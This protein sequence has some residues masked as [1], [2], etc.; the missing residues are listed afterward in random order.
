[1]GLTR[2]TIVVE[3]GLSIL[4]TS[5][6]LHYQILGAHSRRNK[7]PNQFMNIVG[8]CSSPPDLFRIKMICVPRVGEI[9]DI[10]GG[11]TYEVI[12]VTYD[13]ISIAEKLVERVS[14]PDPTTMV[15]LEVRRL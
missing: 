6:P 7:L 8:H 4:E 9:L 13:A 12:K 10:Q 14:D 1:M 5:G 11:R 3:S 2:M 15:H